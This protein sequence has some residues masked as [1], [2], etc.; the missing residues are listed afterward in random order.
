MK[1][2]CFLSKYSEFIQNFTTNARILAEK[3]MYMNFY[4]D[5]CLNLHEKKQNLKM[6]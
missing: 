4:L 3:Y 6:I 1:K 5:I 2:S